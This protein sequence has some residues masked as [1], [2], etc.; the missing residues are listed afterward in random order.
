MN[1]AEGK[2]RNSSKEFMHFFYI[3]KGSRY[4]T[5]TLFEIFKLRTWISAE[6]FNEFDQMSNEKAKMINSLI[7]V[8]AHT[9]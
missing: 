4:E 8:I 3:A 9:L 5:L 1:I 7:K 6:Q 2:G